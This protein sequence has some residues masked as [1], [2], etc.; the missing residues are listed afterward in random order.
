MRLRFLL[1]VL[2]CSA[3]FTNLSYAAAGH[4]T[5]CSAYYGLLMAA[6]DQPSISRETSSFAYL[7]F[8]KLAGGDSKAEGEV[9]VI[10]AQIAKDIPKGEMTPRNIAPVRARFDAPCQMILLDELSKMNKSPE[11]RDTATPP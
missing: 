8:F 11:K 5:L 4:Y 6:G 2:P 9:A 1:L 3:L 10:M 7:T